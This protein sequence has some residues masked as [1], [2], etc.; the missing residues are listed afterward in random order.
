MKPIKQPFHRKLG[1]KLLINGVK[2][3]V[4]ANPGKKQRRKK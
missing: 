4:C 1:S 3:E 2:H